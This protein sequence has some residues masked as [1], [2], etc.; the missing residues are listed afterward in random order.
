MA[1]RELREMHDA[2]LDGHPLLREVAETALASSDRVKVNVAHELVALLEL[3]NSRPEDRKIHA[4]ILYEWSRPAPQKQGAWTRDQVAE[5]YGVTAD[6]VRKRS[7]TAC[8][9]L[10]DKGLR[11][12]A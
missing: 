10:W 9:M 8:K 1:I 2:R 4:A 3:L 5:S 6:E 12:C 11:R 7:E